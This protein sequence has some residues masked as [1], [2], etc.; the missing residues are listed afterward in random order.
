MG[1]RMPRAL[2]FDAFGTVIDA[3][4]DVLLQVCRKALED[5]GSGAEPEA[6]LAAWDGYFFGTEPEP[7]L[8]LYEITADSL[9]RAFRDHGIDLEPEPYVDL[10]EREWLRAKPYPE[11][12]A[13][14]E[15]LDGVPRAI[16][17]NADEAFLQEILARNGLAFDAVVTSEGVRAYKPN[18]RIFERALEALRVPPREAVH[19]GDSLEADVLGAG[20]LGMGTVWVNRTGLR[21]GPGDP[22]P[23]AEVRDLSQV[24]GTLR[25]MEG[26]RPA[27]ELGRPKTVK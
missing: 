23:D 7:F 4:R 9:A 11:V 20:R 14:L 13:A 16:V 12:P 1:R 6:F 3:G 10:L 26:R 17:S 18:P 22:R 8:L 5:A 24:R 25:E 19:V 15:A 2:T 21:R 27:G